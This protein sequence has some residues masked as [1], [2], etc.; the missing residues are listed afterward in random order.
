[1]SKK[2]KAEIAAEIA[3]L[4][5]C[6]TFIPRLTMFEENNHEK[7]D[8]QIEYLRGHIDTTADEWNELDESAQSAILEAQAWEEGE[9]DESPS[10]GWEM[11]RPKPSAKKA[12]R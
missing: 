8:H 2:T 10:E 11:Y 1:M 12:K 5:E 9:S 3:R 7:I 4:E 6:K